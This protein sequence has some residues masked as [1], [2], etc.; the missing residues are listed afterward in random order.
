MS[1]PRDDRARRFSTLARL[2]ELELE[3]ARAAR[4][5]TD[6]A[7][8]QQNTRVK[9]LGTALDQSQAHARELVAR[10][11]GVSAALF[12]LLQR[13]VAWQSRELTEQKV[14]LENAQKL[15]EQARVEVIQRF[16]RL[17]AIER[18]RDHHARETSRER[19]R[20]EQWTMDDQAPGRATCHTG[21]SHK[22]KTI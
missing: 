8:D 21:K 17:S 14:V 7:V 16:Q 22:G 6:R 9:E 10:A 4:A 15:A 2:H 20:R 11:D 12:G 5:Q 19:T 3:E 1:A 18:A 13:Y